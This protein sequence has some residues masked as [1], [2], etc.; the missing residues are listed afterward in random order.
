MTFPVATS[1]AANSDVVPWRRLPV[2]RPAE[3]RVEAKQLQPRSGERDAGRIVGVAGVGEKNG[4]AALHE[5]ERELD[6]RGLR[7]RNDRDFLVGVELHAVQGCVAIGDR[8]PQ[9]RQAAKRRVPVRAAIPGGGRQALDHV[10][11]WAHLRIAATEVDDGLTLGGGRFCDAPQ[12]VG[13]VLLRQ[14]F[15]PLRS[16]AHPAIVRRSER[17]SPVGRQAEERISPQP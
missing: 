8:A 11:R 14:P 2:R 17:R 4:A 5:D 12:E 7:P 10:R 9:L 6:D 13:E 3:L 1:R 15:Q 16:R